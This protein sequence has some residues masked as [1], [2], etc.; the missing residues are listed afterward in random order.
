M[1]IS[2]ATVRAAPYKV[3]VMRETSIVFNANEA[4]LNHSESLSQS[5]SKG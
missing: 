5:Y 1:A 4:F 2:C 3:N